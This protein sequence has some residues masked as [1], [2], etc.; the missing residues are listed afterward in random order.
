MT[1]NNEYCEYCGG[2]VGI[3]EACTAEYNNWFCSR[4]KNHRG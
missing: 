1:N 2:D 4:E 3:V